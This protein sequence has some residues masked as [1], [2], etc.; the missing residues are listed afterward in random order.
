M[1]IKNLIVSAFLATVAIAAP[2][3]I[4]KG[5]IAPLNT[6]APIAAP[7]ESRDIKVHHKL[8]AFKIARLTMSASKTSIRWDTLYSLMMSICII[9]ITATGPTVP[10]KRSNTLVSLVAPNS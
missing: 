9:Y 3:Q 7:M 4:P 1:F 6:A 10:R 5:I 8:S 2:P